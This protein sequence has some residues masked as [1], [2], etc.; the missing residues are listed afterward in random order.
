MLNLLFAGFNFRGRRHLK[1][2]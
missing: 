2:R 1:S